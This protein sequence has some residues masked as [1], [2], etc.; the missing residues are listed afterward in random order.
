MARSNR[1]LIAGGAVTLLGIGLA[2]VVALGQGPSPD[3]SEV[4]APPA[5]ATASGTTS[6]ASVTPVVA[7]DED[8]E[9][10]FDVPEGMEA[11]AITLEFQRSIAG[12]VAPGDRVNVFGVFASTEVEITD[13]VPGVRRILADV[14]VLSVTG[15]EH[16]S[17]G[18]A[19]TVVLALEPDEVETVIWTQTA[20]SLYLSLV[21]EATEASPDTGGVHAGDLLP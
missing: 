1:L 11:V 13:G 9:P 12:L 21:D 19:P 16:A 18:G 14:P 4:A 6:E 2:L 5:A 10:I 3:R 20:E 7:T 8:G 15:A 17:N